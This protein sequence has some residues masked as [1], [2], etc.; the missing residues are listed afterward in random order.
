[1]PVRLCLFFF[2]AAGATLVLAGC[3]GPTFVKVKG[4]FVDGGQP[5]A[6]DANRSYNLVFVP[7]DKGEREI[8]LV[9]NPE[10]E[11]ELLGRDGRGLSPG[12]YQV[13]MQVTDPSPSK[14]MQP[15]IRRFANDQS[16]IVVDISEKPEPLVIDIAAYKGK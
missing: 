15:L 9:N 4:K 2:A 14:R 11:F 3:G 7:K 16:P 1:M 10:G 13:Q 8:G 6:P 12:K 5:V